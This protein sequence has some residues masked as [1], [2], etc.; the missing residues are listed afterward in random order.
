MGH[1]PGIVLLN[2]PLQVFCAADIKMSGINLTL[3]NVNVEKWHPLIP[4]FAVFALRCA[5]S[6]IHTIFISEL[7]CRV[8]LSRHSAAT[9][10]ARRQTLDRPARLRFT[11]A[12][13]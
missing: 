13:V 9:A 10:E 4:Y 1:L 12:F 3:K 7:A 8:V 2:P 6:E 11:S 5:A